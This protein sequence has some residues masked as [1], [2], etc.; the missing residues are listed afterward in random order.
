MSKEFKSS[1]KMKL[2]LSGF[3]H[4]DVWAIFNPN[5]RNKTLFLKEINVSTA[6]L[7]FICQCAHERCRFQRHWRD[8]FSAWFTQAKSCSHPTFRLSPSYMQM[9]CRNSLAGRILLIYNWKLSVLHFGGFIFQS[10]SHLQQAE[11]SSR[12]P[13][14]RGGKMTYTINEI[15]STATME[16]G[17]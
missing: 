10:N 13:R 15:I 14:G 2:M 5:V 7:P 9:L 12:S 11:L 8:V 17:K 16:N 1:V 3:S 4:Y 6:T